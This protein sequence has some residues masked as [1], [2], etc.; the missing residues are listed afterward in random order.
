[1]M[2]P[3]SEANMVILYTNASLDD[4]CL[5]HA[6]LN[7]YETKNIKGAHSSKNLFLLHLNTHSIVFF[8]KKILSSRSYKI[9]L[10]GYATYLKFK[11]EVGFPRREFPAILLIISKL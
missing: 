4:G 11:P 9:E 5:I 2:I 3:N 1:M 7:K 6:Y 8:A 10:F